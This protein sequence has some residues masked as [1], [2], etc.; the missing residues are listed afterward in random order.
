M[1]ILSSKCT[2]CDWLLVNDVTAMFPNKMTLNSK[3]SVVVVVV[4]C[5]V[6]VVVFGG[7]GGSFMYS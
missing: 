3:S 2:P 7:G 1:A 5:F 4:F 6:V